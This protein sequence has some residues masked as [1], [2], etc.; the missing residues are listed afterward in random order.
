MLTASDSI[1]LLDKEA[2]TITND[3]RLDKPSRLQ[4]TTPIAGHTQQLKIDE[5]FV[6]K[7]LSPSELN[8]F[9]NH[10]IFFKDLIPAIVRVDEPSSSVTMRNIAHGMLSPKLMDIKI[11]NK[12]T[13]RYYLIHTKGLTEENAI[14]AKINGRIQSSKRS[15]L[16][17]NHYFIAGY[18]GQDPIKLK[19]ERLSGSDQKTPQHILSAFCNTDR[20]LLTRLATQLKEI[21]N[22]LTVAPYSNYALIS[23]SLLIAFDQKNPENIKIKIIDFANAQYCNESDPTEKKEMIVE[24]NQ[25]YHQGLANLIQHV[26]DAAT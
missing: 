11:G 7:M 14:T 12:F 19:Q 10:A 3:T 4:A 15:N 5:R 2:K 20:R 13:N 1:C 16:C 21:A 26:N 8:F 24:Y 23:S 18:T 22:R 9:K 25:S 17:R 6:Q